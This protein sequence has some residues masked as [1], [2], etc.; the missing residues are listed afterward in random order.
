MRQPAGRLRI[1]GRREVRVRKVRTVTRGQVGRSGAMGWTSVRRRARK[2]PARRGRN[3]ASGLDVR[4]YMAMRRLGVGRGDL[5]DVDVRRLRHGRGDREPGQQRDAGAG[6]DHLAER[7]QARRPE[8]VLLVGAG[9]PAHAQCLV[10]QAVALVE[11]EDVLAD[12]RAGGDRVAAVDEPVAV[13]GRRPRSPRRTAAPR[14][15]RGSRS[16]PR[17]GPRRVARRAAGRAARRSSPRRA[18]ARSRGNL[19]R[20]VGMTWGRRYGASVGKMPSRT[21]PAS[22]SSCS[23]PTWRMPSASSTMRRARS[24]ISAPAGVSSTPLELRSTNSTPSS[25]SSL[26]ICVESVGWLT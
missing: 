1:S 17:A 7:L 26:R 16:A 18:S 24:T 9:Q 5:D 10:A 23:R 22:G 15:A 25:C 14:G 4:Q 6:R 11:Q 13:R 21:V 3:G 19:V 12:E 8:P 20:T 2:A